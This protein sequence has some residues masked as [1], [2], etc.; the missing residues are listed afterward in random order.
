MDLGLAGKVAL[1]TGGSRGIGRASMERLVAEGMTVAFCARGADS[2]ARAMDEL[3][4]N[5]YGR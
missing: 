1:V 2:V 4:P 5:A 3:G